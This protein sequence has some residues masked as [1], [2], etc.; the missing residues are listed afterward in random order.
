MMSDKLY[1]TS[2]DGVCRR[3]KDLL[4]IYV[5][6]YVSV[7]NTLDLYDIWECTGRI[8]G[9]FSMFKSKKN[10][11]ENA[12][13]KMKGII[14]K[15]DFDILYD[16]LTQFLMPFFDPENKISAIWKGVEWK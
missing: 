11:I 5:M 1:A 15:P 9:N 4:D 2:G 7:F 3:V 16:R 14:N 8:P 6:S 10:D 13:S 12:Y